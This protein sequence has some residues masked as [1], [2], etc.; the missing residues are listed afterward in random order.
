MA[1]V[2][3]LRYIGSSSSLDP[4]NPLLRC[5][6]NRWFTMH[7]QPRKLQLGIL[8]HPPL[9]DITVLQRLD[10]SINNSRC[11]LN[12]KSNIIL[13]SNSN[14]LC[15]CIMAHNNLRCNKCSRRCRPLKD[16]ITASIIHPHINYPRLS[17]N[18]LMV[19]RRDH[20]EVDHHFSLKYRLVELL[21]DR[22]HEEVC[23]PAEVREA[24]L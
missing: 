22:L 6:N 17:D 8:I 4:D 16:I 10:L 12:N 13:L 20:K 2:V 15:K 21:L 19:H 7:N 11:K 14:N 9:Q 24:D 23:L 1:T 5:S 18:V 3:R